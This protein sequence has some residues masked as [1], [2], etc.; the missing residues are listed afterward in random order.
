MYDAGEDSY[1]YSGTKVLKNIPGLRRQRE[2]R[3]FELAMT[4]QRFDEPLP[5][6]RFS[7]SAHCVDCHATS[8]RCKRRIS[9]LN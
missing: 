5:G 3:R 6:G 1:C 7:V 2:L 8:L 4:T 9:S